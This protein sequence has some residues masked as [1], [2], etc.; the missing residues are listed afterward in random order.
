MD[1]TVTARIPI[2]TKR[3]AAPILQKLGAS[4]TGLINAAFEYLIAT[5]SLPEAGTREPT[6]VGDAEVSSYLSRSSAVAPA[7]FW[8]ELG[9]RSYKDYAAEWRAAD[10]EAL[11]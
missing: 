6:D 3:R 4:T 5:E 11:A 9:N 2:E 7:E 10:Y 1:T 8:A